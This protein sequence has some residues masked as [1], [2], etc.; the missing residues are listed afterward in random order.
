MK[1]TNLI[2]AVC[3]LILVSGA[4]LKIL[5]LPY[6]EELIFIGVT[7]GGIFQAIHIELLKRRIT[8]LESKMT[9]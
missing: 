9:K 2:Y 5:H 8:E 6:G 7:S 4:V 3:F 1:Y